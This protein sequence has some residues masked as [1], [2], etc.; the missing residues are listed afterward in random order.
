[1]YSTQNMSECASSHTVL[2]AASSLQGYQGVVLAT[3][4]IRD[5]TSEMFRTA[6][7]GSRLVAGA[8]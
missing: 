6:N 7:T 1:M 2:I 5:V 8:A 4:P 3:F